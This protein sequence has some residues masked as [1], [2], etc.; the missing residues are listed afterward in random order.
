MSSVLS[1]VVS[2]AGLIRRVGQAAHWFNTEKVY[3]ELARVLKPGGAFVFWVR[4]M[5]LELERLLLR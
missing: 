5:I 2:G 1:R 3:P 4:K